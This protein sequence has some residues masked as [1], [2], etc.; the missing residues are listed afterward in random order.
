MPSECL[1]VKC[2]LQ[3]LDKIV[4]IGEAKRLKANGLIPPKQNEKTNKEEWS[5]TF[6]ALIK[7][8]RLG[9]NIGLAFVIYLI[10]DDINYCA[11]I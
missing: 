2:I 7:G 1:L 10:Y 6:I 8:P 11:H 5:I 3:P 4:F 9:L